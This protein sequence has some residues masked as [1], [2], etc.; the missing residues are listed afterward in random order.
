MIHSP[1]FPAPLLLGAS[2]LLAAC[3]KEN[4]ENLDTAAGGAQ[5]AADSAAQLDSNATTGAARRVA[6]LEGF[7]TAESVRFDSAQNVW[8]VSNVN[9]NPSVK[10]NNGFISRVRGDG[11]A[12]D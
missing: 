8:F 12:V 5:G 3:A 2:L 6:A 11:S 10:D 1:A 9:G 7:K 4:R